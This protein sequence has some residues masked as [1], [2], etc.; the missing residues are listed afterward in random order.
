MVWD[1]E[2]AEEWEAK[3]PVAEVWVV[4]VVSARAQGVIVYVLP[5]EP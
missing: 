1:Q 5:V 4:V 3:E 2:G